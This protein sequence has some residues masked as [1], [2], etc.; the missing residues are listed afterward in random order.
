MKE[1]AEEAHAVFNVRTADLRHQL[2]EGATG[3]NA[4]RDEGSQRGLLIITHPFDADAIL[5]YIVWSTTAP[6]SVHQHEGNELEE[7][8]P[9]AQDDGEICTASNTDEASKGTHKQ[10]ASQGLCSRV[11]MCCLS[12]TMFVGFTSNAKHEGRVHH[13]H[14]DEATLGYSP[15]HPLPR[16]SFI[17]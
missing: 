11:S 9:R 14:G 17:H 13:Y 8:K 3:R 7:A 16:L 15:T 10:R 5:L 12:P 1:D 2:G 6:L 4:A